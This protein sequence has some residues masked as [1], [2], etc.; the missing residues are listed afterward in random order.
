MLSTTALVLILA[1]FLTFSG[2]AGILVGRTIRAGSDS[3]ETAGNVL[4]LALGFAVVALVV[5]E[6]LLPPLEELLLGL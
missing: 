3:R 5:L 1:L 2:W 4:L 6:F